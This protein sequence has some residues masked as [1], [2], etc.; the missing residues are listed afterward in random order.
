MQ[1][2]NRQQMLALVSIGIVALFVADKVVLSPLFSA[3]RSRGT[4]MAQLRKQIDDGE[5]L[6]KREQSI[7]ER[8]DQMRTNT[9]PN[10][11]SLAEQQILKAFERWSQDSRISVTSITP[12]WKRD[13]DDFM[14]L[15]CRVDA[16][17]NLGTL[18]QFLYDI[19]KDPMALQLES[20]EITARDKEGQQ[21]ALGL[22]ISGLALT[23]KERR[24]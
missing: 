17:G 4:T 15:E 14:T 21:L 7:R 24:P 11:T 9:L 19:E 18:G 10:N 5:R 8:W 22:Q 13:A 3:W 23:P 6:L 12:Q 20:V 16:S 2:K 1:I